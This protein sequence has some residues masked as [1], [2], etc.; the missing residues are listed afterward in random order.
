MKKDNINK[1]SMKYVTRQLALVL[2]LTFIILLIARILMQYVFSMHFNW[3]GFYDNVVSSILC[4]IPPLLIFN[5]YYEYKVR[6]YSANEISE[7]ITE[8]IMSNKLI[9]NSFEKETRERF[10][11]ATLQSILQEEKGNV[12]YEMIDGYLQSKINLRKEYNYKIVLEEINDKASKTWNAFVDKNEYFLIREYLTYVKKT[13]DDNK[14]LPDCIYAG[15]FMEN[16]VFNKYFKYKE[17]FFRENLEIKPEDFMKIR[18]S[19]ENT[20]NFIKIAMKLEAHL[21]KQFLE[22]KSIVAEDSGIIIAFKIPSDIKLDE[23]NRYEI[24]F[25]MPQL[26][27][28]NCFS[29]LIHEPS[30]KPEIMFMYPKDVITPNAVPFFDEKNM[31]NIASSS[32]IEGVIDIRLNNWV[33]PRSGVVFIWNEIKGL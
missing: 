33:Y 10:I 2:F 32:N 17:Y 12:V 13:P 1:E 3:Y 5:I 23:E 27:I 8:T 18:E 4:V 21:N 26:K 20:D 25:T 28:K 31:E 15:F 6:V 7:K 14:D 22:I 19:R 24:G 16:S 30:N 29:A 11:K 9:I